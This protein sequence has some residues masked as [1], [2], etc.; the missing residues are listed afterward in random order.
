MLSVC[1]HFRKIG[2]KKGVNE[3]THWF[4]QSKYDTRLVLNGAYKECL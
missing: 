2:E 4:T 1:G 3:Q